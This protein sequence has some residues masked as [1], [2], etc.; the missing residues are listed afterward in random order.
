MDRIE[1]LIK[2]CQLKLYKNYVKENP[3][4][5]FKVPDVPEKIPRYKYA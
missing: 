4:T 2:S 3:D 1:D 5:E